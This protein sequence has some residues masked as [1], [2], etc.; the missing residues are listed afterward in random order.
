MP[1]PNLSALW[2]EHTKHEFATRD[3][4]AT[5]ATMVDD[6]YVNHVPVMTVRQ[7]RI[8]RILFAGL[9]SKHAAGYGAD[10]HFPYHW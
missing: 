10:T 3:T 2:D 6:A 9:H 1:Q 7:S 5:L 4:E 8:A